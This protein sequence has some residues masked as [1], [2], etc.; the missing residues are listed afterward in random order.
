GRR[1]AA[2][3]VLAG[4]AGHLGDLLLPVAARA[5]RSTLGE[6]LRGVAGAAV[7]R[8]LL[9]QRGRGGGDY[10]G[11]TRDGLPGSLRSY[12]ATIPGA[13]EGLFVDPLHPDG[14]GASYVRSGVRGAQQPGLDQHLPGAYSAVP[15]Q[16]LRHLPHP[17]ELSTGAPEPHRLRAGGWRGPPSHLVEHHDPALQA[18]PRHD[19]VAQLYLALQRLLLAVDRHQHGR[20][21][22]PAD[23]AGLFRRDRGGWG[24]DAVAPHHGRQRLHHSPPDRRLLHRP[25]FC[26]TRGS[27][28]GSERI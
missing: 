22:D 19:G 28:L 16:R 12:T 2:V 26:C 23:R 6:L 20:D 21:A 4:A 9:Q 8:L 17:P 15:D 18:R 14:S 24:R 11:A 25:T 1:A 5:N 10:R 27:H 13:G 3:D 7:R